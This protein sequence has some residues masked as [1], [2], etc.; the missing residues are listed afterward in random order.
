MW[1]LLW[2][3]LYSVVAFL[4]ALRV[5]PRYR[6]QMQGCHV[7]VAISF[8]EMSFSRSWQLTWS[9]LLSSFTN[10]FA[11]AGFA[12]VDMGKK[13]KPKVWVSDSACMRNRSIPLHFTCGVSLTARIGFSAFAMFDWLIDSEGNWLIDKTVI[14][15]S[16]RGLQGRSHGSDIRQHI[17]D[18]HL[19]VHTGS[20]CVES[21]TTGIR[22]GSFACAWYFSASRGLSV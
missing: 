20:L 1:P 7:Y 10:L 22:C 21:R 9:F 6:L 12:G 19:L 4:V 2:N 14:F 5:I 13:D 17:Y 3:C 15:F 11:Q 18:H 16:W 8:S